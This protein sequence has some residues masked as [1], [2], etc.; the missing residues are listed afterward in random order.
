MNILDQAMVIEQEGETLY[1]SFVRDLTNNGAIYIFTWLADQKKKHY[2]SIKKIKQGEKAASIGKS[3]DLQGVRDIFLNWKKVNPKLS[4]KVSQIE[5][6]R[7]ALDVEEKS[8][9]LYGE[10]ARMAAD[11]ATK[12]ALLN[13][14]IEEKAHRQFMENIIEF[15]IIL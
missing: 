2:D 12:T 7:Q 8:I 4:I 11:E 13:L 9:R 14:A 1:R 10:G 5:L 6:Y 15:V 3:S